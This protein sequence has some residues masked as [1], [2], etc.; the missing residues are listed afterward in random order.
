MFAEPQIAAREMVVKMPHPDRRRSETGRQPD[1][2]RP[3]PVA[4]RSPPPLLGQDTE[5]VLRTIGGLSDEQIEKLRDAG[6]I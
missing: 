3:H 5:G 6:V 1:Q 2:A 4:Y